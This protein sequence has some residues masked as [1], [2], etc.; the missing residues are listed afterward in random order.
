MTG[1]EYPY[2]YVD[3]IYLHRNWDGEYENVAILVAIAVNQDSF[4]E[5]IGAAEGMKENKSSWV[6]FFQ[7]L[8]ERGLNGVKLIV[9]DKCLG[10]LEAVCEVFPEAKYQRCT[11]HFY[12]NIFSA[13]PRTKVR[14]VAKMLKAIHAQESKK[15][16]REKVAA[17]VAELQEMK[18][19]EAAKKVSESIDETLT[20]YDFPSEHWM[21]IRTNNT[22]ERLNREIRRR[23]R[24]VGTFP[25]GNSA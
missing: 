18:L 19:K 11:V 9:G 13:V 24:V 21:K 8:R 20:Y 12:R 17:I 25:D 16:A 3:R 10:I 5:V 15:A 22:I 14:L 4:R 7:W 23:T 2:V 1:K 6:N